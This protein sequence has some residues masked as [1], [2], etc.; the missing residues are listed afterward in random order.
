MSSNQSEV[1]LQTQLDVDRKVLPVTIREKHISRQT[2][3]I[4]LN[5]YNRYPRKATKYEQ[6]NEKKKRLSVKSPD[7]K[8]IVIAHKKAKK[9]NPVK[10][11]GFNRVQLASL[12]QNLVFNALFGS[13]SDDKYFY[14]PK[15][16]IFYHYKEVLLY[17]FPSIA[18]LEY[19]LHLSIYDSYLL[20]IYHFS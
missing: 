12:G 11:Y 6:L 13:V 9:K 2:G 14:L 20:Y 8:V 5:T 3:R 1:G 17:S 19:S 16:V 18:N 15:E 10:P 7:L 4:S